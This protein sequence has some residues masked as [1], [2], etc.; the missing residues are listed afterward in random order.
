M[1]SC[2]PVSEDMH[3][4]R[5][6]WSNDVDM[7]DFL[8]GINVGKVI[9][10]AGE[11]VFDKLNEMKLDSSDPSKLILR[12]IIPIIVNT[13]MGVLRV[14]FNKVLFKM[15][16]RSVTNS[17]SSH[18]RKDITTAAINNIYH[19]I[20][21]EEEGL[22]SNSCKLNTS[23]MLLITE[24]VNVGVFAPMLTMLELVVEKELSSNVFV[25][26]NMDEEAFGKKHMYD[27]EEECISRG[28]KYVQNEE[29]FKISLGKK[30]GKE[31][32]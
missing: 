19:L 4:R 31:M 3:S 30:N 2:I 12:T 26:K 10:I 13:T 20:A 18:N 7:M 22:N 17:E 25:F 16:M 29:T 21:S 6:F 14:M 23:I 32:N 8:Q 28:V 24:V 27:I 1:I 5:I 15:L 9:D 11:I